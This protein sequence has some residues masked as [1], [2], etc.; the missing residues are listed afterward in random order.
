MLQ[1]PQALGGSGASNIQAGTYQQ[2][3]RSQQTWTNN[4]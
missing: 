2:A 4:Y 3:Q 1:Q